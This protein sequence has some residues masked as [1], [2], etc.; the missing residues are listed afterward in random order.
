[1]DA[2]LA[3]HQWAVDKGITS[4]YVADVTDGLRQ[5]MQSERAKG[6]IINFDVW[7]DEEKSTI[8]EIEQG[9]IY[10]NIKFTD[11]PVAENPN[12]AI[13]VTNEYLTEIF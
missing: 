6:A 7:V 13:E 1:M 8:S 3:G 5:F 2:I 10:W 12:F 11:V 9:R 4:T